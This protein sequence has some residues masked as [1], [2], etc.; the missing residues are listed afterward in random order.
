MHAHE[1]EQKAVHRNSCPVQVCCV[2]HARVPLSS[3]TGSSQTAALW[4]TRQ[5]AKQ[6]GCLRVDVFAP[7]STVQRPAVVMQL[8]RHPATHPRTAADADAAATA[9]C[10][11]SKALPLRCS[12]TCA[13]APHALHCIVA[14]QPAPEQNVGL[15]TTIPSISPHTPSNPS[16]QAHAKPSLQTPPDGSI[17][18]HACH[19]CIQPLR[20]GGWVQTREG[21]AWGT[22]AYMRW[23]ERHPKQALATL[24]SDACGKDMHRCVPTACLVQRGHALGARHAGHG[25]HKVAA[26]AQRLARA[27]RLHGVHRHEGHDACRGGGATGR[28][29]QV[30]CASRCAGMREGAHQGVTL[31]AA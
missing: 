25:L 19:R 8:D 12:P 29:R 6:E 17:G 15:L 27:D 31:P 22:G 7:C 24:D 23:L 20:L 16:L 11:A 13:A 4:L 9:C 26:E 10:C 18:Q 3:I 14:G 5:R 30:G 28:P 21:L 1:A 2:W